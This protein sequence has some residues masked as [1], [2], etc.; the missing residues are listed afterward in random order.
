KTGYP[1]E[2]L[3]LS[4]DM[5]ADLGIDSIKRV[6]IL[7][8]VQDQLPG[9]PEL[10]P[11]DLA[12]LRTLGQ[13]VDYMQ[14]KL[15]QGGVA[16][17]VNAAAAAPAGLDSA[18]VQQVMMAVVA[19]KTGYPAEMLELSMDME[20]DLGIDSI[21]RVEI[22]GAVQDQLPGLPELN[23]EDLA[24]LRTLGQIVDYMQAKL[25]QGSVAPVVNVAAA[26]PAGLDSAKVQQ[27]M[28]AVV[29][30]K[31]GYPAEM[32]E[33]SMDMEADLGI[34]SIKRVEILGA[35]QDQL[36]GLPELNPE[37]L[38]ELRTL[39]QI[40]DYMQA[41]L[42]QGSVAP[43]VNA[44]AA[45]PAG[46]DSARV[47]QVMMAVVAEKTGYPAEMLELSMD[48]EADL[49]IDSIKRVEILGAVQDQLPGLPELNP[50]DLA[51]LRTLGQIVDY[52][53]AKLPQGS[54]AP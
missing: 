34:D 17:V 40:V 9:L 35:V 46:L 37:D 52:M 8:A 42:P 31:T 48:M 5:E 33:L 38:A 47:Q 51:E 53:Q 45:A 2:M 23:P 13:I 4:M 49:G 29:A 28:M 44:A 26:A 39:G 25:P 10:N 18:R 32:L 54:V 7:G 3:E 24:E 50:E 15:P 12:E 11:E 14:A 43:V 22:L 27:V 16:P 20:A 41:K 1:A 19:E 36:P 21:K 6:E 30:E